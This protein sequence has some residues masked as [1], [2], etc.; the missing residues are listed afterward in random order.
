MFLDKRLVIDT[1]S[2]DPYEIL[3]AATI[4]HNVGQAVVEQ[5][6]EHPS[7]LSSPTVLV[8]QIQNLLID[9][10]EPGTPVPSPRQSASIRSQ[11]EGETTNEAIG[12]VACNS[13][14]Q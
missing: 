8:Q 13:S 1:P 5:T 3:T 4:P 12:R 7:E 9:G 11:S 6:G 2:E 10:L 14:M